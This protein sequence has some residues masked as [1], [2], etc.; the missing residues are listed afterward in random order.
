[1]SY[2]GSLDATSKSPAMTVSKIHFDYSRYYFRTLKSDC[3][4]CPFS[5]YSPGCYFHAES[6]PHL[7]RLFCS[8]RLP[9][10]PTL[11]PPVT[12]FLHSIE[13]AESSWYCSSAHL[14]PIPLIPH[15]Y[16][17]VFLSNYF[18]YWDTVRC[19]VLSWLSTQT[20]RCSLHRTRSNRAQN[21]SIHHG[22]V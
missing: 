19:R 14:D 1:M 7:P 12:H 11:T 4:R 20:S 16:L 18:L 15:R 22:Q 6:W 10:N 17:K 21:H 3:S 2:Y 13:Q 5:Q 8:T 9:S